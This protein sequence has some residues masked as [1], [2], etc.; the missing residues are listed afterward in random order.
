MNDVLNK[1]L[2]TKI[3][4]ELMKL[5]TKTQTIQFKNGH[6]HGHR[7]QCGEAEEAGG[8]WWRGTGGEG[9]GLCNSVGNTKAHEVNKHK[10][11]GMGRRYRWPTGTGKDAQSLI[12]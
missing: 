4:K 9:R 8:G 10:T 1:G 2:I 5:N 12:T 3:V 7:Q 6:S 11:G